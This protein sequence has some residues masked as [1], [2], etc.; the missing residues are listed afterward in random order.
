MVTGD[1]VPKMMWAWISAVP[2]VPVGVGANA[3]P[4]HRTDAQHN[5][6][7]GSDSYASHGLASDAYP[8][9][10]PDLVPKTEDLT[11]D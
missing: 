6:E 9:V 1:R 4:R 2:A 10:R 8:G 5:H 11:P 3:A 7:R